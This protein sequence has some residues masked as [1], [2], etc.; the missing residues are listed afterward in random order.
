M[1]TDL[2]TS[3]TETTEGVANTSAMDTSADNVTTDIE[4]KQVNG[5][6]EDLTAA[7]N[8][9][10]KRKRSTKKAVEQIDNVSNGRPKRN[11]SKRQ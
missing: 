3:S 8:K 2:M 9:A 4:E 1:S 7:E 10:G 11:L 6:D 5:A